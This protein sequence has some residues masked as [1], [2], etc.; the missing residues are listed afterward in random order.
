MMMHTSS[1]APL[2]QRR[3]SRIA[4]FA[5]S[6]EQQ[7][8]DRNLW[9][10]M[11]QNGPADDTPVPQLGNREQRRDQKEIAADRVRKICS[12]KIQASGAV[13][14]FSEIGDVMDDFGNH[15]VS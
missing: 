14:H 4:T 10:A 15:A 1:M 2:V 6:Q 12:M 7:N 11:D 3:R 9:P 5:T 13:Q 8:R